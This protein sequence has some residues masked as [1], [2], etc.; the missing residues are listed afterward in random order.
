MKKINRWL[1]H[2]FAAVALTASVFAP[3]GVCAMIASATR[4]A[5]G[6][7]V[8]KGGAVLYILALMWTI[9]V[10][11]ALV[12]ELETKDKHIESLRRLGR[13]WEREARRMQK[14]IW[15]DLAADNGK[16]AE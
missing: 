15:E 1:E 9:W 3:A 13:S 5:E 4:Y 10:I 16:K 14:V 8:V 12:K 7:I 11:F 6:L 2:N